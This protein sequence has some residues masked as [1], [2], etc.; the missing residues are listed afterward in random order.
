MIIKL[1]SWKLISL[2]LVLGGC[3]L[4]LSSEC[5]R[6]LNIYPLA[7]DFLEVFN[8]CAVELYVRCYIDMSLPEL[9]LVGWEILDWGV[10]A[11]AFSG[12]EKFITGNS[13]FMSCTARLFA[14]RIRRD[15][16]KS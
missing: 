1:I 10:T 3:W 12:G 13:L 15:L 7:I 14:R 16:E 4:D 6:Y 9:L 11:I 5:P 8:N 2:G